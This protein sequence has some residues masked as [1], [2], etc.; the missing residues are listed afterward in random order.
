MMLVFVSLGFRLHLITFS[1]TVFY[2]CSS[3]FLSIHAV[4]RSVTFWINSTFIVIPNVLR[5][6]SRPYTIII[7]MIIFCLQEYKARVLETKYPRWLEVR[8]SAK[9][10]W[11]QNEHRVVALYQDW[12]PLEQEGGLAWILGWS[13]QATT[14]LAQKVETRPHNNN[15]YYYDSYYYYYFSDPGTQLQ[16]MKKTITITITTIIFIIIKCFCDWQPN[17]RFLR[18]IRL[19]DIL[20]EIL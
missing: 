19:S 9:T 8:I 1:L 14:D 13:T 6:S 4:P 3:T 16:E 17:W 20:N 5:L 15:Y 7:T 18:S 10:K 11:L 2:P 12:Q